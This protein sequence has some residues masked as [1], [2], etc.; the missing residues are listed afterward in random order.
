M[1]NLF[2]NE[3]DPKISDSIASYFWNHGHNRGIERFLKFRSRSNSDSS[4]SNLNYVK[5]PSIEKVTKSLENLSASTICNSSGSFSKDTKESLLKNELQ[6]E[7]GNS[8]Q[9]LGNINKTSDYINVK[10]QSE[11]RTLKTKS[12]NNFNFETCIEI[13]M[14]ASILKLPSKAETV[15]NIKSIANSGSQTSNTIEFI[16]ELSESTSKTKL[17]SVSPSDSSVASISNKQ[18]EW[19]SLADIGYDKYSLTNA[20]ESD[21]S[22]LKSHKQGKIFDEKVVLLLK[23]N[24]DLQLECKKMEEEEHKHRLG[25]IKKSKE[26]WQNIYEKYSK[27]YSTDMILSTSTNLLLQK[28]NEKSSQTTIIKNSSR[29]TQVNSE[30]C[31]ANQFTDNI[32]KS[33]SE[34]CINNEIVCTES[35]QQSETAASF[36][37][38]AMKNKKK[39]SKEKIKKINSTASSSSFVSTNNSVNTSY[40]EEL[41]LAIT[42]LKSVLDSK[43]MNSELKKNLAS[44][45][46]QKIIRTQTLRS[47]QTSSID[48]SENSS[49][50]SRISRKSEKENDPF[51]SYDVQK[52]L[53]PQTQS[54][55]EY[56]KVAT[57]IEGHSTSSPKES[58][59]NMKLVAYVKKEKLSQLNWIENEI[60]RLNI[61]RKLFDINENNSSSCSKEK[62]KISDENVVYKNVAPLID[63]FTNTNNQT[64]NNEQIKSQISEQK[65]EIPGHIDKMVVQMQ[66]SKKTNK[67]NDWESHGNMKKYE[68]FRSKLETPGDSNQCNKS[69]SNYKKNKHQISLEKYERIKPNSGVCTN[70]YSEAKKSKLNKRR[71]ESDSVDLNVS[72][73]LASSEV[74]VSSESISLS[75][76][77]SNSNS[78]N[79]PRYEFDKNYRVFGT[80]TNYN[81]ILKT[82]PL[83]NNNDNKQEHRKVPSIEKLFNKKKT[84][85]Q[86]QSITYTIRF[87]KHQHQQQ[88]SSSPQHHTAEFKSLLN[89]K[90]SKEIYN[91]LNL[92][93]H[94]SEDVR[95]AKQKFE[96]EDYIE[97]E[98]CLQERRPKLF[99]KLKERNKCIEELKVLRY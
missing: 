39:G 10:Q 81:S 23:K 70:H 98:N 28:N 60:Y 84:F 3:R 52:I 85:Q 37:F 46:M 34:P 59:K 57:Q 66:N 48:K 64:K 67:F 94:Q 30:F 76:D 72:T 74:F 9:L 15:K 45:I 18:M 83:F 69:S 38:I 49:S 13:N 4:V 65:S 96:N 50:Y 33:D 14:P 87:D 54:E 86:M 17:L 91:K 5:H 68:K 25:V 53:L 21:H 71:T 35:P 40:D 42:L 2:G 16:E 22:N 77:N 58:S 75:N 89:L 82:V 62:L 27:K 32:K 44:T 7:S 95:N 43:N 31:I 8:D 61:L 47:I 80:Q 6:D 56:Q 24:L 93:P 99:R 1:D 29:S 19:D 88:H 41:Q 79:H 92:N 73:S 55:F 11:K 51:R 90:E 63:Q 36:E 97:L 20:N 12:P 78:T 26:K